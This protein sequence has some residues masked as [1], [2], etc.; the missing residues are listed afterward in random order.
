VET[1]R[2]ALGGPPFAA[3]WDAGR[4]NRAEA[5]LTRAAAAAWLG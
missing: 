4:S 3:A 2:E 5:Q 1:L